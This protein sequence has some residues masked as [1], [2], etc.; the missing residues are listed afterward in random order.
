MSEH[1][2]PAEPDGQT[3]AALRE[4]TEA[5]VAEF[6]GN[7]SNLSERLIKATNEA[8]QVLI[9]QP[10]DDDRVNQ[11]APAEPADDLIDYQDFT[12]LCA[13]HSFHCDDDASVDTL[14]ELV[15]E[16]IAA[17]RARRAA[18]AEPADHI[19]DATEMVAP[20]AEGEVGDE[21]LLPCVGHVLRLAEIIRAVD[22]NHDK[23]AAALAEAILSHPD[24]CSAGLAAAPA[25]PAEG[26]VGKLVAWM[27]DHAAHLRKM[28][29]IGAL[30]ETELP[31]RLDRAATLLQQQAAELTTLRRQAGPPAVGAAWSV[32]ESL[33]RRSAQNPMGSADPT[34]IRAAELL[35]RLAGELATL[36]QERPH[37]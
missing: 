18:P 2:T 28:Q 12:E 34:L 6:F 22:G 4:L 33:R 14:R 32:A 30:P 25:T 19:R 7:D 16:A 17:D 5:V 36:R 24:I 11:P 1:P 15:Q 8:Q 9:A 37:A 23:G 27:S 31:E 13:K 20:P 3:L 21:E 10:P 35:E 29:E 26:E